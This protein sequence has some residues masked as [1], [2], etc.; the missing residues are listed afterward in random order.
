[1]D[2]DTKQALEI[3]KRG[4]D[5][6]IP[7][8]AFKK[9]LTS[10]KK[11]TVKAGFDP[12]S[13]DLH[14]GHTV[15]INKLKAFQDLGHTVIFLIGD[16]TGLIGDP[17]GVNETRPN[18]D[19]K[20]LAENS[21]TYADQ[22]FKI[23]DKKKTKIKFNSSWF[24]K[25]K[26]D[27]FIRLSS[28]MTVARMLERD[29]F[30]KR[31]ENNKPISLHEFLYPLVQ[32][33]DSYALKAD[34]ELGGTDQKF[35]LLV[36]REVQKHFGQDEQVT[37]TVP[38][39]EGLD[40]VK[41]MSK[42]LNNYIALNDE[43]NEM[44]GKIMSISDNLM[45]RY[46]DL[47]SF[48]SNDEIASFRDKVKNGENPMTFKKKLATEIVERFYDKKSSENAEIAFTN[49]FSNKLEPSEVPIFEINETSSIS[50]VELL[51]HEDLGNEFI[52]SKSECRRL[53]KQSGIKMN[54]KKVENPD[55]LINLGEENYFQI[56]KRKHLK[57]KLVS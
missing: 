41:K 46:F 33:F 34:I 26:L 40:G 11:L 37:I 45:W 43:P 2:K 51:T 24:K 21:K 47:L 38:L 22:V 15:L 56:G 1:M 7:E 52:Q 4:S 32:G 36:G 19:E 16:F 55:L 20:K 31:Y 35:N 8:D 25:M 12:T 49:V 27:E 10:K 13:A 57:I 44:F 23:L 50:I 48:R 28:I 17:S 3:I 30:K 9:L 5:E 39:L 6:I 42:S 54:N 53:I 14:L 29:D 18:I